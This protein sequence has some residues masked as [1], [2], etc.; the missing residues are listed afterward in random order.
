MLSAV[1]KSRWQMIREVT[2][3]AADR[4]LSSLVQDVSGDHP[5]RFDGFSCFD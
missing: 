5:L 3:V 1:S 4:T 2:N